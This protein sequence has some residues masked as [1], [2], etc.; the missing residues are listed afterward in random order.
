M[1]YQLNIVPGELTLPQL[2]QVQ[3]GADL[4][5]A[6]LAGAMLLSA[7]LLLATGWPLLAAP[8]GICALFFAAKAV[9][10]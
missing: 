9:L 7:T 6:V 4:K 3:Q 1:T 2:R 10:S 8:L 5:L